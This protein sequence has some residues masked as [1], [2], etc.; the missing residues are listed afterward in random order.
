MSDREPQAGP[1]SA[2]VLHA[3]VEQSL[4]LIAITDGAGT[5]TWT[6][7][8]F[9]AATGV[10][11]GRSIR[12]LD[13]AA[14][15][16]A[17]DSTRE[18]LAAGLA[19]GTLETTGLRLRTAD[20]SPLWVDVGA[21]RSAGLML[22]TFT[23]VSS[24]RFLAAQARRQGE[25]LD[26]AQEFGRIGLWE[27]RIPSGEGRWDRH[28]FGFWGLDPAAGT[29][30]FEEAVQ[31]I[32][33][34]DRVKVLYAESTRQAGRYSQ[35]Y[36]VIQP[37]GKTR[38]IH[39]QWAVKNGPQGTPDRAVG[40]MMDDTEAYESARALV[41]V[42][43]QLKLAVDLGQIAI[44]RHDLRTQRMHYSDRAYQLLQQEPRP[45]G[46]SIEEVRSFIHPDDIPLVLDS[47]KK[48][49]ASDLPT[50]MEARYRRVD[51][52]Y[53]Y[54]MTRRVV[55]RDE[56][57]E[58]LAFVGVALDVTERV[59]QR[60]QAEELARRLEAASRAAGIGLWT[61]AID[62][63]QTDWN[64]QTFAIFDRFAPPRV[65]ALPEWL[66][67]CVHADDRERVGKEIRAYLTQPGGRQEIEFRILR[68]D[69]SIRWVVMRADTDTAASERRRILGVVI[70]VTEQ[71]AA[72]EALRD[73]SERSALIARH[74]GIGM[75]EARLDGSPERW[76]DQ[77]FH[78]RGLLPSGRVPNRE[79]RMAMVH[80]DDL[81]RVLDARPGGGRPHGSTAYEFRV[82]LPDGG[83]RW[84]ASRSALVND[85]TGRPVR[86]VGVNW[87]VT[88]AK[89]AELVRQQ[90]VLAEREVHAKSQFLS[91]MS[92]ELRTPL[93][94]V[95]GFTQLLQI[96]AR[97]SADAAQLAKLGHIRAAGDHLLSLI[98]DVLDLSSLE[99]GALKLA[100]GAV[101][102]GMLVRQSVPLVESLAAQHGVVVE[103]AEAHGAARGDATRLRQV[104]I[105]LLSN[106]IKYNRRGGRVVVHAA[107]VG[108]KALLQVR[109]TGRGLTPMQLGGLFEP[110][111]RF[112]AE[113]E[114]IEGTGIGLTIVKALVEGMGGR[115]AVSSKPGEGTLFEVVLATAPDDLEAA[116]ASEAA[117]SST[118]PWSEPRRERAGQIL[119]IEDNQVNVLLV[120]ELVKTVSGLAISSEGTG[121]AGVARA[122]ALR[123]DLVL[124]DLQLP[125]FDGFEVLR[126][127]RAEPSTAAIPCI[128]LS[129][130]AMPEDIENGLAAGFADYWTKPIDF[131]HFL[132]ALKKRFPVSTVDVERQG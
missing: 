105:N 78:L 109:D 129:A 54:V 108:D 126:R 115:V 93:N 118:V 53:R 45:E 111:N 114:G 73:A 19:G 29:P 18:K 51:G 16:A 24:T 120:E 7:S 41:D 59:E 64:E 110:F 77:M 96:E 35:R 52:S 4:E 39:S 87:D 33:P 40:I 75:W 62:P 14:D 86:R 123:P 88:E 94:A 63:P 97:R 50:D 81:P 128:A 127:L 26:T 15:G 12:L 83:W 10:S 42:N 2:D 34:D 17:G 80:P 100:L 22:W 82:R 65:P 85:D 20:D 72:L 104:L 8:R 58:P 102:L 70:D 121:R 60:Q 113:N 61:T 89:Q 32:H 92:H 103:I 122:K 47:A 116:A 130:N 57:G 74:A 38:L 48:A 71:H 112:G 131:S 27:R 107:P 31:R 3:L 9:S 43:A 5:I 49:L 69:G 98:N 21:A 66:S 6:N 1:L 46:F 36:R 76:D 56:A 106:A 91:R 125:D 67:E 117:D 25:M 30:P 55:E 119:Y 132:T 79:E 11:G 90:A 84:L 124:I 101:D 28:V 37:D 13:C 68:R 23:D 44:C 99:S 95:L